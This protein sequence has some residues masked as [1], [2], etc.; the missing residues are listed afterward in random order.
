M[1]YPTAEQSQ[2]TLHFALTG[3]TLSIYAYKFARTPIMALNRCVLY[4]YTS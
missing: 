4:P 3:V 2:P 1:D